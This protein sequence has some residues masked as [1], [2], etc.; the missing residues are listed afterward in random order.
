[1][2]F[3]SEAATRRL[4]SCR[5]PMCNS[6]ASQRLVTVVFAFIAIYMT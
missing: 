6:S 5:L 1:V 2:V 3:R 4:T